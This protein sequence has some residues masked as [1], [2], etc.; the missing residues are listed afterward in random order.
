[1]ERAFD[2]PFMQQLFF[3][4]EGYEVVLLVGEERQLVFVLLGQAEHTLAV[5]QVGQVTVH[6]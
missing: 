5:D 2:L 6:A 1:M 3:L 4:E